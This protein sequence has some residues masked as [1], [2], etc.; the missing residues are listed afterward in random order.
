MDLHPVPSSTIKNLLPI[1]PVVLGIMSAVAKMGP[2]M[3]HMLLHDVADALAVV[4]FLLVL[5]IVFG[6]CFLVGRAVFKSI[7]PKPS[8]RWKIRPAQRLPAALITPHFRAPFMTLNDARTDLINGESEADGVESIP[9]KSLSS[10][11]S[12]DGNDG[13][14]PNVNESK[15]MIN[16]IKL[17]KEIIKSDESDESDQIDK[18]K[19]FDETDEIIESDEINK[20]DEIKNVKG[21]KVTK[22]KDINDTNES[23][24]RPTRVLTQPRRSSRKRK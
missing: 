18:A 3:T 16:E 1:L 20:P 14:G 6:L 19:E 11:D 17:I 12:N 23:D 15:E 4:R 24:A 8:P 13:N 5:F 21:N 22:N 9:V 2:G 7:A 10:N